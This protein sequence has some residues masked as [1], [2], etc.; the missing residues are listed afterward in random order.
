VKGLQDA[1][2]I[3]FPLLLL[4]TGTFAAGVAQASGTV[5]PSTPSPSQ[6][7]TATSGWK[8]QYTYLPDEEYWKP[9]CN[10]ATRSEPADALKCIPLS[11]TDA[12]I[13]A[14][15]GIDAR[16]KYEHFFNKDWNPTNNGYLLQRYLIDADVH[17]AR[18]REF[19]EL[20]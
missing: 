7:A 19:L 13:Y 2:R 5:A 4:A 10:P 14:T 3:I 9:Y 20:E 1:A 6:S 8:P 15:L 12:N 17:E 11:E 18:L 16:E